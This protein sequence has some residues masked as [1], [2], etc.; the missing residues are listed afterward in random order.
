M[1]WSTNTTLPLFE[2][3]LLELDVELPFAL[4]LALLPAGVVGC[5]GFDANA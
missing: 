3:A 4:A 2:L 5:D 1:P